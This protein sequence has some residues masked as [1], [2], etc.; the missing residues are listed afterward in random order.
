MAKKPEWEMVFVLPN[1][2]LDQGNNPTE[3]LTLGLEG[4]A[5]VPA[6]DE[7]VVAVR[8][9]SK[10]ADRFLDAFH[11]GTGHPI[12]PPVLMVRLDWAEAFAKDAEPVIAFRNAVAMSAVALS[13]ARGPGGSWL[14]T[15]WS[16]SY[17]YHPAQL[18]LDGSEFDVRT[19][20]L[21]SIGFQLKG[22][23]IT[24]DLGL[25][26][27]SLGPLDDELGFRLGR[28]WRMRYLHRRQLRKTA[29]VFRSLETAYEASSVGF[30]NYS[31]LTE[32]GMD[33]KLS[34]A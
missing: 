21:H 13:R 20:A 3:P 17:D 4:I 32:V 22:L 33:A 24:P 12:S 23:S 26:R 15:S 10:A 5:I 31:S 7:R 16:D 25:P 19:P 6:V 11:D 28:V 9:W 2:E 8:S 34:R 1:L 30:K 18:R 27:N 29:R 14:G